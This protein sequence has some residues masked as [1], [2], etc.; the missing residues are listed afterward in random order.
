MQQDFAGQLFN[1]L[2]WTF[3][4]S[5][6]QGLLITVIAGTILSCTKRTSPSFRYSLLTGL[7]FCFIGVTLITFIWQW[8]LNPGSSTTQLVNISI[9]TEQHISSQHNWWND[10]TQFINFNSGWIIPVWATI[11]LIKL[12]RVLVD[13]YYLNRLRTSYVNLPEESWTIR[14]QELV[15]KMGI[16]KQVVLLESRLVNIPLVAGHFKPIILVPLGILTRLS[17]AE[18][19]AVLLHELAHIRRHDYLINLV[20]RVTCIIFF[21]NPGLLW[22]SSLIRSERENCCDDIAI[23][24]TNDKVQFIEALINVKQHSLS[25]SKL[26]MNFLGQKNLLHQ[27]V[28]RI[29]Y[30]RNK[31]L[32]IAE[33]LFFLFSV[34]CSA[35]LFSSAWRTV[36]ADTQ[37]LQAVR[38]IPSATY[39]SNF[40]SDKSKQQDP[41]ST[42]R[43]QEQHSTIIND[44]Q[45]QE[46]SNISIDEKKTKVKLPVSEQTSLT[47]TV[48][49]KHTTEPVNP[50]SETANSD[51]SQLEK[52][53]TAA[54]Q[55]RKQAEKDRVAAE[56]DRIQAEKDRA[57]AELDRKQAALDRIQAEKDRAQAELDRKQADK[58]RAQAYRNIRPAGLFK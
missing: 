38:H 3:I 18:V 14:L 50:D 35:F 48:A 1:A 23:M 24:H 44:L 6:W 27:R 58:D 39:L 37:L 49:V 51:Y 33:L 26:V 4:H 28:N 15:N 5:L 17:P 13:F 45:E 21:F 22:L 7:L 53:R 46:Q 10:L 19:E 42:I 43:Y 54:E 11:V 40:I 31:T 16:R 52:D 34:V 25:S 8:Q 36:P 2:S 32:N 20:Q 41:L 47:E 56:L 57:Q 30:S 29:V 12:V 9:L 55:D